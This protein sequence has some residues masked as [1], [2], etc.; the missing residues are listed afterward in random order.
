SAREYLAAGRDRPM[1]CIAPAHLPIKDDAFSTLDFLAALRRGYAIVIQDTR[2]RFASDE[3]FTPFANE[4]EDG[5]DTIAWL[6]QKRFCNGQVMMFAGPYVGDCIVSVATIMAILAAVSPFLTI[7]RH[8][9]T[10]TYRGGAHALAFPLLWVIESLGSEDLRHRF[11]DLPE[12]DA[13]KVTRVL[14]DFQKDP[15]ISFAQ[16]PVLDDDLIPLASYAAT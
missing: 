15:Q 9:D 13:E 11:N 14:A 2:G 12:T 4:A 10:W 6:R 8:G 3:I 1:A 5:T 7:A 16:L